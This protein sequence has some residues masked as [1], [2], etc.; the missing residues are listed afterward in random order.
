ML[1]CFYL[2]SRR[3]CR[4]F[5]SW[6][7]FQRDSMRRRDV[8][9]RCAMLLISPGISLVRILLSLQPPLLLFTFC[10]LAFAFSMLSM[11]SGLEDRT[12]ANPDVELDWNEFMSRLAQLHYCVL[13]NKN[14][15]TNSR[16]TS[17]SAD[18]PKVQVITWNTAHFSW[19]VLSFAP[20]IVSSGHDIFPTA[21]LFLA[22]KQPV[23]GYEDDDDDDSKI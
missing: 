23:R 1:L 4:F 19:S 18:Q 11:S 20:N 17:A 2:F 22:L 15:D 12:L 8:A 9:C 10:L 13:P 16:N 14:R 7:G 5:S 6:R 21:C 3:M